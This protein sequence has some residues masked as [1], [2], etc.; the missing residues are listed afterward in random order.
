LPKEKVTAPP[1]N[2][3]VEVSG[4]IICMFLSVLF[5][6]L[7]NTGDAYRD[8]CKVIICSIIGMVL[9]VGRKNSVFVTLGICIALALILAFLDFTD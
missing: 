9:W 5:A 2:L 4:I 7:I 1:R 6:S 8:L 3:L